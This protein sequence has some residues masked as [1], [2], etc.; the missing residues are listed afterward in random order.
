MPKIFK[1]IFA[2][3]K[4]TNKA[5]LAS[6]NNFNFK[7]IFILLILAKVTISQYYFFI[8]DKVPGD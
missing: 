1:K 2:F 3:Y 4:K 6:S 7:Y 5:I 8:K